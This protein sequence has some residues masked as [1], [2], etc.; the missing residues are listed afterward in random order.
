MDAFAFSSRSAAVLARIDA[1]LASLD[2]IADDERA[3]DADLAF[4]NAFHI[5]D[6]NLRHFM[7]GLDARGS[8][9][10]IREVLFHQRMSALDQN[11]FDLLGATDVVSRCGDLPWSA[12]TP[13][14][15]CTYHL[16]SYKF[17][18][19]AL[20]ARGVDCLLFVSGRTL[21]KQGQDFLDAAARARASRGWSGSLEIIDAERR[22]SVLQGLRALKRGTALVLYADGNT[23]TGEG[24]EHLRPVSFFGRTLAV[25]S[26]IAYLSHAAGAPIVPTTCRRRAD[27][28]LELVF[29]E[30]IAP[31]TDDRAA[32]IDAALQRIH[33]RLATLLQTSPGQWEG[34]LYAHRALAGTAFDGGDGQPLTRGQAAQRALDRERY[35]FLR[36]P[37]LRLLL[38]KTA[39]ACTV[40]EDA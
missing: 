9:A 19:H 16:G 17:L 22:N 40:V 29:H 12:G 23:G 30:T 11:D 14:I 5:A 4:A 34:W 35:A 25:R 39:F 26:G 15:F 10:L 8:R 7:P 13:R 21:M 1:E 3:S 31:D 28:R 18:F 36:Y 20:A 38:D 33:D 27:G 32:Y 2:A 37:G 6:A 24:D